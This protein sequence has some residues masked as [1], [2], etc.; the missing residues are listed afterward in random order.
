MAGK[1]T[2]KTT[3]RKPR[4]STKPTFSKVTMEKA[5]MGFSAKDTHEI[6]SIFTSTDVTK[7]IE[8]AMKFRRKNELIN[9]IVE[10]KLD[11]AV[12]GF[13]NHY[14][15]D[16]SRG[17]FGDF[18]LEHDMD[19]IVTELA[20][21]YI[22]TDNAILHWRVGDDGAVETV[23]TLDPAFVEY[24]NAMGQETL[25]IIMDST[26]RESLRKASTEQKKRIPDKYLKASASGRV[27][28]KNEDGEYWMVLTTGR[29]YR[30]LTHPSMSTVF[31]DLKLREMYIAGDWSVAFFAKAFIQLVTSGEGVPS[32][33]YAGTRR[34]YQT[35]TENTALNN[36]LKDVSRALRIVGNHTLKVEH[37][38]PPKDAYSEEKYSP[39]ETRILRWGG[40]PRVLLEGTG[41]NYASG[42]IGK[43]KFFAD[44]RRKRKMLTR[45]IEKFYRQPT[46][47]TENHN[48]TPLVQFDEQILK[49]SA[50]L[51]AELK[52]LMQ[53]ATGFSA[54][55]ALEILGHEP[56][57]ELKRKADE[58]A[59][60]REVLIP[61]FE[62]N[63]G[64]LD[65]GGRPTDA[66]PK[67]PS[68]DVSSKR[69]ARVKGENTD[70]EK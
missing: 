15:D 27:E 57:T 64:M 5:S 1:T 39:V 17:F 44:V 48:D 49:D 24:H 67:T 32:G 3:K 69:G 37:I 11:F 70:A 18:I 45:F 12:A 9:L 7:N 31:A 6:T 20:D 47:N 54:Q 53:N 42:F 10:T 21:D 2:K 40:I 28:L 38:V 33:Q 8:D 26:V 23:M 29:K 59:N 30:G 14:K 34:L 4:A 56:A 61:M 63:Q 66:P 62:P 50:E 19:A 35:T 41:G 55:S 36:L 13:R 16:K 22:T 43:I 46:I 65:E 58:I 25:K 51:L 52:F 68:N 60:K